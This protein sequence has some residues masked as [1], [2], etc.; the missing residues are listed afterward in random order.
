MVA[1]CC[2]LLAAAAGFGTGPLLVAVATAQ[3]LLV[4]GWVRLLAPRGASGVL[5]VALSAALAADVLVALATDGDVSGLAGVVGLALPAALLH[6]LV[7]RGR[8]RAAESLAATAGAVVL[9]VAIAVLVPLAQGAAGRAAAAVALVAVAVAV[10]LSRGADAALRPAAVVP[11]TERGWPGLVVALAAGAV[12]GAALA[13][14]LDLPAAGAGD[15][16]AM[17][18]LAVGAALGSVA[19][20]LATAADLFVDLAVISSAG[21]RRRSGG[22]HVGSHGTWALPVVALL[23]VAALGPGAYAV[24]RILLG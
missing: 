10:L 9:V 16:I 20:A 24:S 12:V 17:P 7:R 22:P 23:P 2:L 6:Q 5:A 1:G 3:L 13:A 21:L 4:A 18:A 15:R 19:A 11:G 14:P 8:D